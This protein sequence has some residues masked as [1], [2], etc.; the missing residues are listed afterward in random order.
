MT[1]EEINNDAFEKGI[2]VQKNRGI[3]QVQVDSK[4]VP[5]T[6]SSRLRKKLVYPIAAASSLRHRVLEV[7]E[8]AVV[9]PVAV[10]DRVEFVYAG[11]G[12]GVIHD[13]LPR[14]S[15]FSRTAA[16][17]KKLEQV[18][19]AN[20]DLVLA[21]FAAVKPTPHWSLLDRYLVSAEA[22]RLPVI[23]CVTKLDIADVGP[24]EKDLDPYRKIGY[25]VILTSSING[26]GI[27]E[28]RS[29]LS[30]KLSVLMGKSG[31]GKTSLL[32][33]I[34]PGLGLRVSA[35]GTGVSGKGRHTTTYLEMVP[36][37]DGGGVV[38]TPGMREFS[39]WEGELTDLAE[40]FPEMREY[41]GRCQFR[42]NCSHRKEPGCAIRAAVCSGKIDAR[43]YDSY[44]KLLQ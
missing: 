39:P 7:E 30:G 40:C 3:Y 34:Q 12:N 44:L 29:A 4:K 5:C 23:I 2:V 41:L 36:L 24:V 32:N 28:L 13:V 38:D 6:I 42:A 21:V 14:S 8:I 15:Q 31:V 22:N 18:M 33:A 9:D 25:P 11:D 37:S 27:S 20:V 17:S 26:Q 16:G 19:V 10:G 43:R 1:F 35:V